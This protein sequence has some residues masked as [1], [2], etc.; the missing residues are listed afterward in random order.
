MEYRFYILTEV[1]ARRAAPPPWLPTGLS[2]PPYVSTRIE[3]NREMNDMR[4]EIA[5]LAKELGAGPAMLV[6]C[7]VSSR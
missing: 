2:A 3:R 6:P 4:K 1:L 5:L 7:Y